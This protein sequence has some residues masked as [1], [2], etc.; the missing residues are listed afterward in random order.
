MVTGIRAKYETG[1]QK[2][3][4]YGGIDRRFSQL[5]RDEP[6]ARHSE[7]IGRFAPACGIAIAVQHG[8]ADHH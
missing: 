2:G 8:I 7:K 4:R 1:P 3:V 5:L 6:F